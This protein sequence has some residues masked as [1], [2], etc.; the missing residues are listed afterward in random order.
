MQRKMT[1]LTLWLMVLVCGLGCILSMFHRS[2]LTVIVPDLAHDLSLSSAQLGAV[3]AVYLYA[4][5]LSQLPLG[6]VLDRLGSRRVMTG[7]LVLGAGGA[8]LLSLASGYHTALV[9]RFMMGAGMSA[10]FMGS[11]NLIGAWFPANKFGSVSGLVAGSATLGGLLAATPLSLLAAHWGWRA[12]FLLLAGITLAAAGLCWFALRDKPGLSGRSVSVARSGLILLKNYYFWL[13][14][15]AAFFRYGFFVTVQ[16]LWVGPFLL[17]GLGWSSLAVANGVLGLALGYLVGLPL[18][19]LVS[20]RLLVSRKW[21]ILPS[22]V[23][24]AILS[25]LISFWTRETSGLT[26]Y[27]GLAAFGLLAAPG[28][29]IFAHMREISPPALGATA[30]TWVNFFTLLGGA[31]L[32][33]AVGCFLPEQL[34]SITTPEPFSHMWRW[35]A[36]GLGLAAAAYAVLPDSN[37]KAA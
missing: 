2:S 34:A 22:L 33:Q 32:S 27:I 26:V 36:M 31:L 16:A 10:S 11:L 37:I 19:G 4:F 23:L 15:L 18:S 9:G 35:G 12:S 13:I 28:T 7:L 8:L 20:D 17:Y 3:A 5:A 30:L 1:P 24:W 6:P 29:L 14:S 21:V 25:L